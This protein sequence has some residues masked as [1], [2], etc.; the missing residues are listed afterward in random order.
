MKSEITLQLIPPK[1]ATLKPIY[2]TTAQ[3]RW[4]S[5]ALVTDI[6]RTTV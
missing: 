1:Y 5:I 6:S 2:V 3:P 4:D